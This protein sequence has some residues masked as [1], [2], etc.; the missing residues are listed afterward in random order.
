MTMTTVQT[1]D[2]IDELTGELILC[3]AE[4]AGEV[5]QACTKALRFGLESTN[6]E[7]KVINRDQLIQEICDVVLVAVMVSE[8]LGVSHDER[9]SRMDM[10][11]AKLTKY[12]NLTP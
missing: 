9:S 11:F 8:R 2:F 10:K 3:L 5:V 7:T 12:L 6:P 1:E 4:E